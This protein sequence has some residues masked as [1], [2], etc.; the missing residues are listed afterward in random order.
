MRIKRELL[1]ISETSLGIS[2]SY[3]NSLIEDLRNSGDDFDFQIAEL[4]YNMF[5]NRELNADN[6]DD[7]IQSIVD[8]IDNKLQDPTLRPI[9]KNNYNATKIEILDKVR[10]FKEANADLLSLN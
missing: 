4:L 3:G 7:K 1:S 6:L 2:D 9:L 5:N 10:K 8:L